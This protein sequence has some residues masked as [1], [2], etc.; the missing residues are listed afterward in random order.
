MDPLAAAQVAT[1]AAAAANAETGGS[2]LVIN[3]FWII[4]SAL[5]FVFFLVIIWLIFYRPVSAMLTA[6]RNRIEQGLKDA[7]VARREREA[8]SDER[9]AMLHE[10]RQEANEILARAQKAAED[11]H[12]RE[13]GVTRQEIERL[14]DQATADIVAERQRALSEVRGQIADLA[15]QAAGKV[16]G[17]TRTGER[18]RRLVEQFL[19]E[20]GP[21]GPAERN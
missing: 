13:L 7:D 11:I 9:Q 2:G 14:R 17:E 10:A 5:N 21:S 6:R 3:F 19:A 15:L 20:V 1:Q 16:V 18:E 4:V 12:A 8:A